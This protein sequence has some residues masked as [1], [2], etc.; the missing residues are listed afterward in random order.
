MPSSLY[1]Y[2]LAAVSVA[3]NP[4]HHGR[5]KHLDRHYHW[6]REQVEYG[7]IAPTY[8]PTDEN[9]A[10]IL[11]KPLKKPK[12]VKMREMMGLQILQASG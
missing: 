8:L 5:M 9:A 11:T 6:L 10:D 4:E 2:N 1:I 3:K 7:V 12:V